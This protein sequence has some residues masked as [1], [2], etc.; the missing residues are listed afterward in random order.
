MMENIV[1]N[2]HPYD[3]IQPVLKRARWLTVKQRIIFKILVLI[4]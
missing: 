2:T 1:T 4:C 3:Y